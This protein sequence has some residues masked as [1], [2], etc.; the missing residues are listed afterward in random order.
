[1]AVNPLSAFSRPGVYVTEDTYGTVPA[2]IADHS[3]LY[4]LGYST[5]PDILSDHL[6]FV[7]SKEDFQN[8]AGVTNSSAA[9]NLFFQQYPEAGFYFVSVKPRVERT[10]T[11]TVGSIGATYGITID[12]YQVS[13]LGVSGDTAVTISDRL[14]TKLNKSA[15]HLAT[16]V[17][18]GSDYLIRIRDVASVVTSTASVVL[19]T[20]G[21]APGYPKA[22]DVLDSASLTLLGD[23]RQ[24]FIACPEFYQDFAQDEWQLLANGLD[25]LCAIDS[26]K[27]VNLVDCRESVATLQSGAGAINAIQADRALL[28]SPAGHTV[29]YFPYWVD[30]NDVN[31]PMS[32]TVAAIAIKRYRVNFADPPAGTTYPVYGTKGA[33]YKVNDAEHSILNPLGINCGRVFNQANLSTRKGSVVY[34]ARTISTN[35]FWRFVTTRVI[36]NVLEGSLRYAF[37]TF[38]FTTLDGAGEAFNRIQ[39][40]AVSICERLRVAKAFYGKTPNDAYL[41]V[42]NDTN[43][44]SLDL[45]NGSVAVDVY[46]K[47]S[48]MLEVLVIRCHRTSLDTVIT[49]ALSSGNEGTATEGKPATKP[50]EGNTASV[51]A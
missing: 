33:T 26:H 10:F 32:N 38:I 24:G 49:E 21:V 22:Q 6:Y 12:G 4:I 25:A 50:A 14:V 8:L 17:K 27:W 1:M 16:A 30:G 40:T 7:S 39:Q 3:T 2:A 46:F 43:N 36:A 34:G 23:L 29:L 42:C 51:T 11:V 5:D 31:V 20:A 15:S 13:T 44:P 37:D 35:P 9:V 28:Q 18:R 48:P 19:G 47:P 45:E 41:V